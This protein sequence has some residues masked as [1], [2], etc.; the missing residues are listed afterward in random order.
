MFED[1]EELRFSSPKRQTPK[2]NKVPTPLNSL[3]TIPQLDDVPNIEFL[4]RYQR[5]KS[6]TR[7][8]RLSTSDNTSD[9]EVDEESRFVRA[10]WG[11]FFCSYF[12]FFAFAFPLPTWFPDP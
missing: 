5:H 2:R 6:S 4:Q 7:L 10:R 1:S 3:S 9:V 12:H 8:S 11:I